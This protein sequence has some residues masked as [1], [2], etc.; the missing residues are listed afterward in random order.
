MG[1]LHALHGALRRGPGP[2][3]PE[4]LKLGQLRPPPPPRS[5]ALAIFSQ[6]ASQP[7]QPS[8]ERARQEA[9]G[10]SGLHGLCPLRPSVVA[11]FTPAPPPPHFHLMYVF[12]LHCF[13][14]S[15]IRCKWYSEVSQLGKKARHHISGFIQL[16]CRNKVANY[17][18]HTRESSRRRGLQ[19]RQQQ[20][21]AHCRQPRDA[22]QQRRRESCRDTACLPLRTGSLHHTASSSNSNI[23]QHQHSRMK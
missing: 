7:D 16:V 15:T 12:L 20:S 5:H 13:P 19:L 18:V 23:Q 11:F 10:T 22:R 21:T 2:R 6:P 14:C 8:E 3:L 9:A 1:P 4:E 17:N